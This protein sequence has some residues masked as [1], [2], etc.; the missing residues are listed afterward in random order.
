MSQIFIS[1]SQKDQDLI[2]LFSRAF[3]GTPV[4][5]YLMEFEKIMQGGAI[6]EKDIRIKIMNSVA[7]FVL[8]SK[9]VNDI[10]HT[11][12]WVVAESAFAA[13]QPT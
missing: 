12:D 1:H 8:L 4:T 6:N 9:N 7:L 2:S 13:S 3:G 10:P 5:A 11:R